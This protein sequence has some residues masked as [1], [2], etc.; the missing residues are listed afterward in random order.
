MVTLQLDVKSKRLLHLF[1]REEITFHDADTRQL[2]IIQCLIVSFYYFTFCTK[3]TE[4]LT[5]EIL[6]ILKAALL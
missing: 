4:N 5:R 6:Q 3:F 1:F 2:F